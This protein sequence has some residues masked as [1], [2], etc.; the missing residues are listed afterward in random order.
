MKNKLFFGLL[1]LALTSSCEKSD[2]TDFNLENQTNLE[3]ISSS[4]KTKLDNQVSEGAKVVRY[5]FDYGFKFIDDNTLNV[6]WVNLDVIEL[7]NGNRVRDML[8][9][10]EVIRGEKDGSDRIKT[11]FKGREVA[12]VIYE[13]DFDTCAEYF[14]AEP[15]FSGTGS[16]IWNDNDSNQDG[17]NAN[18]YGFNLQGDGIS[19]VFHSV[20]NANKSKQT[21]R[22]N[23]K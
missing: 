17:T 14:D 6:A 5:E 18:S 16:F 22:I 12:V 9:I 20:F 3:L 23:L 11:L 13:R 4:L 19:I 15:L 8:D 1:A 10:Q 21:T 7:C 2:S